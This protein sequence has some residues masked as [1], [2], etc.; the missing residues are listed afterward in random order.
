MPATSDDPAASETGRISSANAGAGEGRRYER[1]HP[2]D[3]VFRPTNV[4]VVAVGE[5]PGRSAR[6]VLAN[7]IASP[8]GG[9]VFLV[10]EARRR[11]LGVRAHPTLAALPQAPDLAVIVGPARAAAAAVR[12]CDERGVR[13][14]LVLSNAGETGAD[15]AALERQ[16]TEQSRRDGPRI[17]GPS[18]LGVMSPPT[19]LNA[20]VAGGM[21]RSGSVALLSQSGALGAAI[22]DW[23][24]H[25]HVGFSVVVSVGSMLGVGWGDLI[26]YLGHDGHT[27]SIVIYMESIGEARTFLSAA[28]EVA[29]AKPIIVMKA[30]RAQAA[31]GTVSPVGTPIGRDEALDAA[32]RRC[33]VLRIDHVADLFHMAEVL[34]KQPRPRGPRLAI[35]TSARAPGMLAADALVRHGGR[36]ADLTEESL[37]ALGASV[38]GRADTGNPIELPA[39]VA[40]E[41]FA[42]AVEI[43]AADPHVDGLLAILTPSVAADPTGTAESL[44]PYASVPDKPMLASW[45]GGTA[46]AEGAHVLNAAGI[47]V[48][49]HPDTA[50]R[51]FAAMWRHSRNLRALYE[52]PVLPAGI[53]ETEACAR[54]RGADLIAGVRASGRT[55]LTAVESKALLSAYDIP[56]IDVCVAATVGQAVHHAAE[57]GFPV[58]LEPHATTPTGP[59]A[60]GGAHDG[61]GS[62][63]AVRDAFRDIERRVREQ[64]PEA[65]FEGVIVRP[66]L[67]VDGVELFVGSGVDAEFGPLLVFGAGGPH[68]GVYHDRALAL[69]PLNTTLARRAMEQT[70][71]YGALA[72]RGHGELDEALAELLVRFSR[73]VCEQPWVA[74]TALDPLIASPG[75][76]VALRAR[77]VVYPRETAPEQL[78]ALAI[79]PYPAR[80]VGTCRLRSGRVVTIRPI[81][82][83]DEPLMA[84][85]HRTLSD[86]SV[87][88]RYFH[89]IKLGQR[90]SHER[91]ARVCFIDYDRDMALVAEDHDDAG[92]SVLL[93]VGRLTVQR[94]TRTGEFAILVSDDL[95]GQGLGTE[96][97]RR[98]VQFGRDQRLERIVAD[99]LPENQDMQHVSEKV[100]FRCRYLS[101]DHLVKA[102]MTL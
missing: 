59:V 90:V 31:G 74:E 4:A 93:G 7:L 41:R 69:P 87:Y 77:V 29:L 39:D 44:T 42:K 73:L 82:P 94:G 75:S 70:R 24:V 58:S 13:A 9:P 67:R 85:F 65:P 5:V 89:F 78:P 56:V 2:L 62:A 79:R 96:L 48:L 40:P 10:A 18:S 72:D 100:G 86:R 51:V 49:Q 97:L 14:V 54:A 36:L 84:Q 43:G 27:R 80:Y 47:P 50:A 92:R 57:M 23:G 20:T 30:G 83:E 95:Q 76:I 55:R 26:D 81:R 88:M 60:V 64:V 11:V 12:A 98:V 101:D 33:G 52:T 8:F 35:V 99:M 19:G 21:A 32:F 91:L 22:L 68:A 46:V 45:M 71:I 15:L 53:D 6:V 102:E 61:L 25:E 66:T 38:T 16:L 1:R 3:A 28:R 34:S 17:L 63:R 37:A